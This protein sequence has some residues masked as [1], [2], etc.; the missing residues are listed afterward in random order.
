[1]SY[2]R[3]LFCFVAAIFLHWFWS[4]HFSFLGLTPQ[5]LL[6]LTIVAAARFGPA[7]GMCVGFAW[8]LALDV[9][10]IHLFGSNALSLV[11]VAYFIGST[12]KQVD[13][14]T[15]GSLSAVVLGT[16]LGFF[17]F[18]GL[19]GLLF[20]RSFQWVGWTPF[21]VDPFYNCLIL[22]FAMWAWSTVEG[23]RA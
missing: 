5:I 16:T 6:V 23:E 14:N 18:R 10:E 11:L 9:H 19:L 2:L 4:T 17:V 22:P 13:M 1:M 21:L 7:A 8:G 15:L 20:L 12:R 3:G